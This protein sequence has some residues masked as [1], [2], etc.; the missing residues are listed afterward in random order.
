MK[1]RT[2]YHRDYNDSSLRPRPD[3]FILDHSR[4][5]IAMYREHGKNEQQ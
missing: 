5:K 3:R 1:Q 2:T 4:I